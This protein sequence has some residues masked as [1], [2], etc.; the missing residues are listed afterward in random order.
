M[1]DAYYKIGKLVSGVGPFVG[2]NPGNPSTSIGTAPAL[3]I[4]GQS[5]AG[6]QD[7]TVGPTDARVSL[8]WTA[9]GSSFTGPSGMALQS[10]GHSFE[11]SCAYGMAQHYSSNILVGK[12][13]GDG[14][15]VSFWKRNVIG[16]I[17]WG[18]MAKMLTNFGLQCRTAGITQVAFIWDQG[19]NESSTANAGQ[20]ATFQSDT[21]RLFATIRAILGAFGIARVRFYVVQVN[22][23]LISYNIANPGT[24]DATQLATVRAAQ[25]AIAA[26]ADP[27]SALVNLD[28]IVPAGG[29][30]HYTTGQTLTGGTRINNQ[31]AID[32]T[33]TQPAAKTPYTAL[34]IFGSS[35]LLDLDSRAGV[36][37]SP[38]TS[39]TD[40]SGNGFTSTMAGGTRPVFIATAFTVNG[41]AIPALQG[42]GIA[43]KVAMTGPTL[44]AP[45]TTATWAFQVAR[46]DAWANQARL[47]GNTG[48]NSC[49]FGNASSPLFSLY[50]GG[51]VGTQVSMPLTTFAT[52]EESFTNSTRTFAT[53]PP[54]D[55]LRY[56]DT[57]A[58][59][60]NV[61]N[62]ALGT[63]II[64][65]GASI[66]FGAWSVSRFLLCNAAPS[67]TVDSQLLGSQR[68]RFCGFTL[69]TY[70]TTM[71][72]F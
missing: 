33:Q 7:G 9:D 62:T 37:G 61:G 68:D 57:V 51:G 20:V 56:N 72:I 15:S 11:W 43:V 50:N 3:F 22:S 35:L 19:E 67:E 70:G 16:S 18:R 58:A 30:L 25:A 41:V 2:V 59:G 71:A 28:D 21:L 38:V 8:T 31:V 40:Q 27:D 52:L 4:S 26:G 6:N 65:N 55:Y 32:F 17:M 1:S 48:S 44:P 66:G 39:W 36:T 42:D 5:N 64:F 46:P 14:T 29:F 23:N 49:V 63:P 54:G 34:N 13:W 47:W 69:S 24:I 10:G 60:V 53:I 12:T 45:G